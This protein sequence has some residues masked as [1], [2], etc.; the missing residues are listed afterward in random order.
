MLYHR[1]NQF[2]TCYKAAARRARGAIQ[3]ASKLCPEQILGNVRYAVA[4]H[5]LG[6]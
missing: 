3:G 1:A 5:H 4:L 6:I 2:S